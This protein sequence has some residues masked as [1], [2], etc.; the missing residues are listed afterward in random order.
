MPTREL[1][2]L[3]DTQIRACLDWCE[4]RRRY[5]HRDKV[6]VLLSVTA[7]LRASEI[8]RLKRRNVMDIDGEI[9]P[10]IRIDRTAAPHGGTRTIRMEDVLLKHVLTLLR[11]VPGVPDDPL[12]LSERALRKGEDG[13]EAGHLEHMTVNSILRLFWQLFSELGLTGCT[14]ES[15]RR[16]YATRVA[17]L[18]FQKGGSIRD[19]QQMLGLPRE[20][21]IG[22]Y[23]EPQRDA[24]N[25]AGQ[26]A[27]D[28][29]SLGGRTSAEPSLPGRSAAVPKAARRRTSG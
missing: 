21:A 26:G 29:A 11:T 3:N 6:V 1:R 14:S 2:I 25:V 4:E 24:Q 17:P 13:T 28:F 27:F 12:I 20:R 5:P 15:G 7:G 19:V 10:Q 18:V 9:I 22:R 23:L 8:A 16:T